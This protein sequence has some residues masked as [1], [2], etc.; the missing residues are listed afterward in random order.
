MAQNAVLFADH[1][2]HAGPGTSAD[3]IVFERPVVV[4]AWQVVP[5]GAKPHALA[6]VE[7]LGCAARGVGA[8]RRSRR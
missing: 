7:Y 1:L 5:Y 4:A 3:R 2:R 6:S 8:R